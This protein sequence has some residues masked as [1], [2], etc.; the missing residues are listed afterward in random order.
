MSFRTCN[1]GPG[2]VARVRK[3]IHHCYAWRISFLLTPTR[4]PTLVRR[5]DKFINSLILIILNIHRIISHNI[6]I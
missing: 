1:V 5:N 4:K 6:L 2:A 3:L